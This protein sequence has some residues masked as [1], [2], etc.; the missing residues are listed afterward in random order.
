MT[1]E[2][3][4]LVDSIIERRAIVF[5][6]S[7]VSG[8]AGLPDW[9][10]LLREMVETGF[11]RNYLN[12]DEKAELLAWVAK[13]DYLM[14]AD[15]IRDRL[16]RAVF[17]EFLAR[18]FSEVK[19]KP[20]ELHTVL[21]EMPFA[22]FVTT[23]FD[24]L[25]ENAWSAVRRTSLEVLTHRDRVALRNPLGRD[26]PFL[27][28]THGCASQ[29][30]SLVLGLR[31]FRDSIHNNRPCQTL[32]QSM[33]LR[34]QVLFIGH[35][36]TDPD[37]L[38]LLDDLVATFDV[39]PG[40]HFALIKDADVGPLRA[41]A[42]RESYGIE[43]LR[44]TATSGH[45]E[46]MAFVRELQRRVQD[47]RAELSREI[48]RKALEDLQRET[49]AVPTAATTVAG[50]PASRPRP[51]G[52]YSTPTL[53]EYGRQ[54][55]GESTWNK[56]ASW[57]SS[58]HGSTHLNL[59]RLNLDR[60]CAREDLEPDI[61]QEFLRRLALLHPT[62]ADPF[63]PLNRVAD[64]DPGAFVLRGKAIENAGPLRRYL[65]YVDFERILS[66]G[67]AAGA[68]ID[69]GSALENSLLGRPGHPVW[70]T[71]AS[72]ARV[73]DPNIIALDLW[74][75]TASPIVEIAYSIEVLMPDNYVRI[76]TV[77]DIYWS[78]ALEFINVKKPALGEGD[79]CHTVRLDDV[80]LKD[81][82][83]SAVHAPLRLLVART[84]RIGLRTIGTRDTATFA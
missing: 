71:D 13:P 70:C 1:H 23:N 60:E 4:D 18:K 74:P 43:V 67:M 42:F 68:P 14:L 66:E 83:P 35:S 2:V 82:T 52:R 26:F 20:T 8:A 81:R 48:G 61:W 7:G 49:G 72:Y 41:R 25:F 78:Q 46:V 75:T 79:W 80:T 6:G 55:L 47:R 12:A 15:A 36:L 10:T 56:L 84:K 76:A 24:R 38:F 3:G 39:P 62:A 65:R 54:H 11:D 21:A 37:L 27:L 31:E 28:K 16:T 5:I 50:E 44:Y 69:D 57:Y 22:A 73:T 29:P 51:A 58:L 33:F 53:E 19:T 32:L 34:Y 59:L 40:R 17:Q 45:P 9:P 30:E 77:P 63:A 64:E